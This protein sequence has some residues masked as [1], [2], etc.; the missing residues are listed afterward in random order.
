MKMDQPQCSLRKELPQ[1]SARSG[2]GTLLARK[3]LIGL[4]IALGL[5]VKEKEECDPNFDGVQRQSL[6]ETC[7][8]PADTGELRK[9]SNACGTV[10]SK[11]LKMMRR[12]LA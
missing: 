6:A 5:V 4:S 8:R 7:P 9:K 10:C 3:L 12:G 2:R 1:E 11:C